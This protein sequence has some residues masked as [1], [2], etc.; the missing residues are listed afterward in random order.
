MRLKAATQEFY[1]ALSV[2]DPKPPFA[3][4]NILESTFFLANG[5]N[6]G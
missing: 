5:A 6:Q 3:D 2:Y 1:A 4:T